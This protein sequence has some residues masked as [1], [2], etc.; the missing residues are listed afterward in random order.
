MKQVY[1]A[2]TCCGTV[3]G[4][5]PRGGAMLATRHRGVL[6]QSS[7]GSAPRYAHPAEPVPACPSPVLFPHP[8]A[9][10]CRATGDWLL[11]AEHGP[12][13]RTA[14]EAGVTCEAG[15]T[16]SPCAMHPVHHSCA[17]TGSWVPS[18]R[19]A[20]RGQQQGHVP[21]DGAAGCCGG[22][23]TGA[24]A[25]LAV[26]RDRRSGAGREARGCQ[27]GCRLQGLPQGAYC[28]LQTP[29]TG[30]GRPRVTAQGDYREPGA[31]KRAKGEQH[32]G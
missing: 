8:D 23:A 31:A 21:A 30:R 32:R 3:E 26:C 18:R 20:G 7:W 25:H 5:T 19:R 2:D 14:W 13:G 11:I 17:G 22:V 16:H 12:R 6:G 4:H 10:T 15:S 28:C 9:S 1:G 27:G 29:A 24:A